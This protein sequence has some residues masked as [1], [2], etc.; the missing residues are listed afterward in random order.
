MFRKAR[1]YIPWFLTALCMFSIM[2][3][4]SQEG[5]GSASL[6]GDITA[7]LMRLFSGAEP[8]QASE[9]F[10]QAHYFVRKLGHLSEYCLLGLLLGWSLYTLP[11]VRYYRFWIVYAVCMTF[12]LADEWLQTSVAGRAGRFEDVFIDTLGSVLS[13]PISL[14]WPCV[15]RRKGAK[16]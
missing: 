9:A 2:S 14:I 13:M 15:R 11:R 3:F 1:L 16:H 7:F 8:A 4:S 6:S 5:E 10:A 12:A